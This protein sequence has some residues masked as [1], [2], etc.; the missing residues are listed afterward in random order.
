M[1]H[2]SVCYAHTVQ[3]RRVAVDRRSVR[4]GDTVEVLYQVRVGQSPLP[5]LLPQGTGQQEGLLLSPTVLSS[6]ATVLLDGA[7]DATMAA[8]GPVH[9]SCPF[10]LNMRSHLSPSMMMV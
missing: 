10:S 9:M 3:P 4:T 8:A 5:L 7:S 1:V 2:L 6:S